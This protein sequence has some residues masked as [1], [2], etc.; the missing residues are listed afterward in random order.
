[1]TAPAIAL[2]VTMLLF[3]LLGTPIYLAILFASVVSAFVKGTNPTVIIQRMYA[4]NDSFSLLAIPFFYMA[5]DLMVQGGIASR[6]V[7]L[8]KS[9]LGRLKGA[10]TVITFV[11]CAFF[12][13][14]SGSS[15]ATTASI[16]KIM[17]PEMVQDGYEKG[18]A[19]VLQAV[20]GTLGVLIPPSILCVLYGVATGASVGDMLLYI[21]PVGI[22]TTL[23]Y[24]LTA[25]RLISSGKLNFY[26]A[27]QEHR[28]AASGKEVLNNLKEAFWAIL[29]PVIILGGIYTGVCTPTECAAIACM[30]ALIIGLFVYRE[31]NIRKI[32]KS[33]M[34]SVLGTA[35]VIIIFDTATAF[36]YMMT[37][38]RIASAVATWV[39][40]T[41][42]SVFVFLLLVNLVYAVAGMFVEGSV[43]IT[44]ITPLLFPIAVKYGVNP[45]HFGV[46]SILNCIIGTLTPPFGGAL[47]IASGITEVPVTTLV[48][49]VWPFVLAGFSLC[50]V[51]TYL[52]FL[53]LY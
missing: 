14:I 31:L 25:Q 5:G 49:R 6:L 16:G 12:G 18:F 29:S 47:F 42:S 7:N 37:I 46:V 28:Y 23:V 11:A 13:A 8:A 9:L 45:I 44:V 33:I 30:Y 1:M 36:S 26:R 43:T 39:S 22:A 10:L 2:I 20:G 34:Q 53:W 24:I 27:E 32:F 41:M 51:I 3:L 17:Y 48:R 19:A 35:C 4:A 38:N 52:P 40:N 21:A 50:L 15:Y